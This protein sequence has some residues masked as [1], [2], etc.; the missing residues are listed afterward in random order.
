[1][2][3]QWLYRHDDRVHGPVSLHDL[4]AAMRL[5]FVR[6][7]DLV[8]RH[9]RHCWRPLLDHAELRSVWETIDGETQPDATRRTTM[10]Q[11]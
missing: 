9:E 3:S 6:P 4:E 8:S 11:D 5:G 10:E 7:A 1:M 2:A